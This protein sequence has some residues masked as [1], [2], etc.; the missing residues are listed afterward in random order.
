MKQFIRK[1]I[2]YI[3]DGSNVKDLT[4]LEENFLKQ[5][6]SLADAVTRMKVH[7][8]NTDRRNPKRMAELYGGRVGAKHIVDAKVMNKEGK[9]V[10]A[11]MPV[12]EKL[13]RWL[14]TKYADEIDCV[15]IK[16]EDDDQEEVYHDDGGYD[17]HA[18]QQGG[19]QEG[20]RLQQLKERRRTVGG[21]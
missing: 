12:E 5:N 16:N 13:K 1:Q 6:M 3:K 21:Q 8:V 11:K 18:Q 14:M 7:L 2:Q 4:E 10:V 9:Q 15:I 20:S 17:G 19:S